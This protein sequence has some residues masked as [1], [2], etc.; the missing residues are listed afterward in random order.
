MNITKL[1]STVFS[2]LISLQELDLSK[3]YIKDFPW[4]VVDLPKLKVLHFC[5]PYF[6]AERKNEVMMELEKRG[7]KLQ[8]N[9]CD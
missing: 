2:S 8:I 1:D 3:N 9:W 6:T 5:S 7:K 4:A